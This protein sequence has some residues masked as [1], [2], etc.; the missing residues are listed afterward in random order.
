MPDGFC[1]RCGAVRN[2][3]V[4]LSHKK[5][6]QPDGAARTVI[7]RTYHCETC[8]AFVRSEDA[9]EAAAGEPQ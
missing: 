9:E 5:V 2:L 3:R 7:V 1:P 4:T 6:T 8:H